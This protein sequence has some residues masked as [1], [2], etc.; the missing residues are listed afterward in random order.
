MCNIYGCFCAAWQSYC[1]DGMSHKRAKILVLT[2]LLTSVW[3]HKIL[4]WF[5][6]FPMVGSG[7]THVINGVRA[8]P[9]FK[10]FVYSCLLC[11]LLRILPHAL[12]KAVVHRFLSMYSFVKMF[13][14]LARLRVVS[15]QI[16]HIWLRM[17]F[18]LMRILLMHVNRKQFVSKYSVLHWLFVCCIWLFLVFVKSATTTIGVRFSISFMHVLYIVSMTIIY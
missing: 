3:P 5:S 10:L 6:C 11:H 14:S 7:G 1:E 13:F 15:F 12:S 9:L 4:I 17:L 8:R 2:S 16:F 18:E